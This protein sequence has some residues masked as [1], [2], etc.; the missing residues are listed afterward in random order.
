MTRE[1]LTIAVTGATGFLGSNLVVRLKS[2][3][4]DVRPITRETDA[5]VAENA[6]SAADVV[7][8]LAGVNRPEKNEDFWRSNRDYTAWAAEA[9][10]AGGRKPLLVFSSSL[11]ANDDSPY[12]ESKHAGE[13]ALLRISANGAAT[14]SIWRLPNLCGKWS[15]PDYNSAVA[16]FCHNAARGLP[17]R[18]DDPS[19]PLALLYVDDLIDQWLR[20]I[21]DRPKASGFAEPRQVYRTTVGEVAELIE[22]FADE[23]AQGEVRNVES[24]LGRILYASFVAALPIAEANYRL[25]AHND[26]RGSFVEILKIAGGGQFS[27]FSARPGVTRGGHYHHSKV[28]KFLVAHGTGRFRF[29][30]ILSGENFEVVSSASEPLMIETIPGW[31]HDVTNI[32]DDELVVLTWASERFDPERPDTY[33]MPL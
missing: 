17:L 8:H 21:D 30:Q 18:I 10:A 14:V 20:L 24:G 32:G 5:A 23:R 16:T 29:R 1:P 11:K 13:D 3:G 31:A 22:S 15:R 28:E 33:P 12:G 4:H 9:V 27:Y 19:T 26:A 6:L 7:F 2:E 25:Q